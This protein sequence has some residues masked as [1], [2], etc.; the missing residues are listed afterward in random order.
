MSTL[1]IPNAGEEAFLDLILASGY[2]L[3]LFK[4]DAT[5]SESTVVGDLTEAD[6]TGYSSI[7]LTGGS[8]VTTPADPSTGTYAQQTFTSSADQTPQV[9]YGYYVT[10]TAGGALR[11]VEKFDGSVTVQF[12]TDYIKVTPRL[13]LADTT[14]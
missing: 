8:W 10:L 14:D 4:N 2:T 11:W 13:T 1:V 6:F 3:H 7:A 9:I 12:D 5:I